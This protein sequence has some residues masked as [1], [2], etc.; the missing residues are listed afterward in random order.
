LDFWRFCSATETAM[1][2]EVKGKAG[3]CTWIYP[4]SLSNGK[5]KQ[6]GFSNLETSLSWLFH[7]YCLPIQPLLTPWSWPS[8]KELGLGSVLLSKIPASVNSISWPSREELGLG[9]V[10]CSR[11]YIRLLLGAKNFMEPSDLGPWINCAGNSLQRAYT[12]PGLV[13]LGPDTWC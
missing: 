3:S 1:L 11:F 12:H 6:P 2:Q 5:V 10:L 8:G 13:G 7:A 4:G 9:T